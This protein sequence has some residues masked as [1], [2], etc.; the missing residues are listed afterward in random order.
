MEEYRE[1]IKKAKRTERQMKAFC[2]VSAV[3]VLT[4]LAF[5]TH[6]LIVY[7]EPTNLNIF[8]LCVSWAAAGI[9]LMTLYHTYKDIK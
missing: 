5:T 1:L 3:L 9:T 6:G 4:L 2:I 8:F 7:E